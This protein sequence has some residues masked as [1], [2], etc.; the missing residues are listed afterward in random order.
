MRAAV[1]QLAEFV[2]VRV[3]A[4]DGGA[5]VADCDATQAAARA[6]LRDR[7]AQLMRTEGVVFG[8]CHLH[9]KWRAIRDGRQRPE[10]PFCHAAREAATDLNEYVRRVF[11]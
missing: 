11:A 9:P 5:G 7:E 3:V 2:N 1:E 4:G 8:A 10:C 6:D